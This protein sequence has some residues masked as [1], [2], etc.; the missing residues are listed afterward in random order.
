M[1]YHSSTMV[2]HENTMMHTAVPHILSWYTLQYFRYYHGTHCGTSDITIVHTTV[3]HN[4]GTVFVLDALSVEQ[5]YFDITTY[6]YFVVI[7]TLYFRK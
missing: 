2:P 6:C 4:Y 5:W 7:I 1:V 3:S